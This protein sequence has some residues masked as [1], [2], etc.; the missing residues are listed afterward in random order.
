MKFSLKCLYLS[1]LR[2]GWKEKE[3]F[4]FFPFFFL[5]CQFISLSPL[6]F[7]LYFFITLFL[8]RFFSE[9]SSFP[10]VIL[11][12]LLYFFCTLVLLFFYFIT[13]RIFHREGNGLLRS[14][15]SL[16]LFLQFFVNIQF[17]LN[18]SYSSFLVIWFKLLSIFPFD[19][20]V[21]FT[22]CFHRQLRNKR[23][24][25]SYIFLTVFLSSPEELP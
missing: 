20:F 23:A 2:T 25:V 15:F 9:K 4:L 17:W 3:N 5:Q 13:C 12:F 18:M 6:S 8:S 14:T 16:S 19:K 11:V 10:K 24:K 1:I 7:F 21:L 22:F